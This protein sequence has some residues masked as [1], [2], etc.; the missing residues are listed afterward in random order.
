MYTTVAVSIACQP[1]S[2]L[3]VSDRIPLIGRSTKGE[4]SETLQEGF[5]QIVGLIGLL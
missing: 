2:L 3:Y 1:S 4:T 5:P